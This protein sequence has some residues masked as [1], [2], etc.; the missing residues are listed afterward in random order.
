VKLVEG[1]SSRGRNVEVLKDGEVQERKEGR[2][3][4]RCED[5]RREEIP[6]G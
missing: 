5:P 6:L 2:K 1:R 4:G 3:E